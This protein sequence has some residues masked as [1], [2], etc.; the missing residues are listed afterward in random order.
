M[1]TTYW[2]DPAPVLVWIT[3]MLKQGYS[4]PPQQTADY[5]H[6]WCDALRRAENTIQM[7]TD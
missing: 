3:D 1:H 5:W 7:H 2:Y 4:Q 6:G